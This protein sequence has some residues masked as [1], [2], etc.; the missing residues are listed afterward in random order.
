MGM[1]NV[2]IRCENAGNCVGAHF[3]SDRHIMFLSTT[4]RTNRVLS[5][6]IDPKEIKKFNSLAHQWWDPEGKFRTLH[7]INEV[8]LKFVMDRALIKGRKVIEAGCGGGVLTES[9]VKNGAETT[10]IDPAHGPLAV[11]KIHAIE[12]GIEDRIR[13]IET[14]TEAFAEEEPEQFDVV[15]A[16]EMLEHVP[17]FHATV[18]ALAQLTRP[19]GNVFVSTINRHPKAYLLAIIGAEYLL[20]ILPR[21]THDYQKFIKP[22]ELSRT[23]RAANL[24]VSEIRGYTYQPFTRAC[25]LTND[26]SVNYLL[27][28]KKDG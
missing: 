28:A 6:N 12:T 10:G 7:D 16:M 24:T 13:Y 8:R 19:G 14:S 21:G 25:R 22:S 23:F 1:K 3:Q 2:H 11:A 26:I 27:H 4:N 17:D 9:F 15:T 20:N 18:R 5:M